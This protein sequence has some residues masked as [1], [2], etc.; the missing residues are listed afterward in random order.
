MEINKEETEH[1]IDALGNEP[2]QNTNT[3]DFTEWIHR[4]NPLSDVSKSTTN[5]SKCASGKCGNNKRTLAIVS[6]ILFV[7]M[8]AGYGLFTFIG[9]LFK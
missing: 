2:E 7:V 3:P 8:L 4:N 9:N 6:V 1:L 5:K